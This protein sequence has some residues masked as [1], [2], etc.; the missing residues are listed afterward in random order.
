MDLQTARESEVVLLRKGGSAIPF[1]FVHCERSELSHALLLCSQIE[2][3]TPCYALLPVPADEAPLITVE[4]MATRF[5]ALIRLIQPKGPYRIA[6]YLFGGVVAYEVALQLLGYDQ[7]VSFLALIDVTPKPVSFAHHSEI[8]DDRNLVDNLI[9][10][11][12][13]DA[14][15]TKRFATLP[16]RSDIKRSLPHLETKIEE[17]YAKSIL[18]PE[19]MC[20]PL[21]LLK[22]AVRRRHLY[23]FAWKQY[24]LDAISIPVHLFIRKEEDIHSWNLA[25]VKLTPHV[26][27]IPVDSGNTLRRLW[28][29]ACGQTL[30]QALHGAKDED[31]SEGS[32]SL[33]ILQSGSSSEP[34]LICFPGA[35][36]SAAS[37]IDLTGQVDRSNAVCGVQPRGI[38]SDLPPHS[39]VEAAAEYYLAG[40]VELYSH[41]PLRLIGHSFGGW[42]AL[43]VALRL[44]RLGRNV[45]SLMIVDSSAPGE[46]KG[47]SREFTPLEILKKWTDV[48]ELLLN[49]PLDLCWSDLEFCDDTRKRAILH[50]C[51]V[52]HELLPKRSKPDLL[53][54]PLRTFA[55]AVRTVYTPGE[56]FLGRAH[57]ML[58]DDPR[59]GI[60]E[61]R[62]IQ[63]RAVDMWRQW[64]PNITYELSKGNHLTILK[65]PHVAVVATRIRG[66]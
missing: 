55:A 5:I 65:D 60:S 2:S 30:S 51:L 7:G 23:E 18:P 24:F 47:M 49:S 58:T 8:R 4:G 35:G 28:F 45:Q 22:Q 3:E 13:K 54:G 57:L 27:P 62:A 39:S 44:Q 46:H 48:F 14:V 19:F 41:Q 59:K 26:V 29:E 11:L 9:L 12:E 34:P 32:A 43:E 63:S 64:V 20:V 33:V 36:A 25:T 50:Q 16:N 15:G 56:R 6:G 53:R 31:I 38:D 37:F 42:I 21:S 61:N 1:F 66:G 10:Y 40:I 17:Y 52:G